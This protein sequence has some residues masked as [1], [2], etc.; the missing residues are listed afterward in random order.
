MYKSSGVLQEYLQ[1]SLQDIEQS[2]DESKIVNVLFLKKLYDDI[3][4]RSIY[5]TTS[6]Q[7]KDWNQLTVGILRDPILYYSLMSWVLNVLSCSILSRLTAPSLFDRFKSLFSHKSSYVRVKRALVVKNLYK[8]DDALYTECERVL[9]LVQEFFNIMSRVPMEQGSNIVPYWKLR[10]CDQLLDKRRYDAF[11]W[12]LCQKGPTGPQ[13]N[14][15]FLS[16]AFTFES[17]NVQ[18]FFIDPSTEVMTEIIFHSL[19]DMKGT[20]LYPL[21]LALSNWAK[22]LRY[23][24]KIQILENLGPEPARELV[25]DALAMYTATLSDTDLLHLVERIEGDVNG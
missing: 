3:L 4:P 12:Y 24:Y 2:C 6:E 23:A 8:E 22:L 11:G 18:Y 14:P 7:I 15:G 19:N 17:D 25:Y 20:S 10:L 13:T 5:R 1:S 16:F 21:R 9:H